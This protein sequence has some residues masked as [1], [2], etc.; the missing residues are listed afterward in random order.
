M[1]VKVSRQELN[2]CLNRAINRVLSE[3]SQKNNKKGDAFNKAS[4]A[5][6][7]E[8]EREYRG[9]GFKAY[10]RVHDSE[11]HYNRNKMPK[12][13]KHNYMDL[14]EEFNIGNPYD[15][16]PY[17]PN[18]EYGREEIIRNDDDQRVYRRF[19][20]N[21]DK[22]ERDVINLILQHVEGAKMDIDNNQVVFVV[23]GN[24]FKTFKSIIADI[25]KGFGDDEQIVAN[26]QK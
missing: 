9:E 13:N 18:I 12:I 5:A 21:L 23:P 20:T 24:E 22:G 6:N 4:K 16:A 8:I 11:K 3:V 2:E 19:V 7:R 14:E 17:N 26:L 15:A 25:N 10:D 1:K